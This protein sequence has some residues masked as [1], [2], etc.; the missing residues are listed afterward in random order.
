KTNFRAVARATDGGFLVSG[1]KELGSLEDLYVAKFSNAGS[2]IWE[3]N[4]GKANNDQGK[5]VVATADGG[6]AAA[7]STEQYL[8]P[9]G[10]P[11]F[12]YLVKT[13]AMGR[14]FTSYLDCNIFRDFNQSC[15]QDTLEPNLSGWIVK[16]ESPTFAYRYAITNSSMGKFMLPVDTGTYTLTLFPPNQ[17]WQPCAPTSTVQVSAFYDTVQVG[18]PV[19]SV[20]DCPN[21]QVDVSTPVLRH[22][23]ENTYSLRYCNF[24]TAPSSGTYVDVEFDA[25]LTVTGSS[26]SGTQLP[27]TNTYRYQIGNLNYGDC[28]LF[29]INAL[30]DCNTAVGQAHCVKAHIYP[31]SFCVKPANWDGSIIRA[32][33]ICDNDTA[34]LILKNVG[35]GELNTLVEYVI[36]ED[37]IMLTDPNNP[38]TI[39][40]LDPDEEVLVYKA[41][42]SSEGKTLRVI[43]KQSPGY[44][45]AD[46][47]PTAAIEAC[48]A[49]NNPNF[50]TGF[51]TMFPE[52]DAD[53]FI[54]TD[55]QESTETDFTPENL[56]R[57][58]P[59]GYGGPKYVEPQTD[60]DFLI[61]F[62]NSGPDTVQQVIIRDTLSAA[63]DPATVRPG[64]ASHAYDFDLYGNGI[65]QFTLPTA[66]LLPDGSASEGFVR[67]RVSQ[68]A[69]LPCNTEIR[70]RAAIYFDFNAPVITGETFHTVCERD[71][72]IQVS[73]TRDIAWPG[74]EVLISP[75]PFG[76]SALF[77][78]RG[79][80]ANTYWLELY[81]AQGRRISSAFHHHPTFRLFRD[82]MPA[83]LIYYRLA[84]DGKPV[85]TGKLVVGER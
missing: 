27:G 46:G 41:P 72:F 35:I 78:V 7:G 11:T 33:A 75:N 67:F 24:G 52:D 62:R 50:S 15:Q 77:E 12:A 10:A 19:R 18:L 74:A 65:V 79:V 43:A 61:Q 53:D 54:A 60:L 21:N 57:G 36:A 1:S 63:L 8:D 51:Y 29:T 30:L 16:I 69:G 5:A 82:K 81:D 32:L 47:Y 73:K 83:G 13:D 58:H 31:D 85:A 39:T 26:I 9:I 80:Q 71:S 6:V 84:A 49:D 48:V 22:C 56:K 55:C 28:G 2:L 38:P 20:F 14:V 37:I 70:N 64:A 25:A 4:I 44:P 23:T 45:G 59:K 42:P 66:N 3:T 17:Y 76:Q 40:G 34:K 68:R